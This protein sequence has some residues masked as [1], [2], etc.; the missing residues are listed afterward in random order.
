MYGK[1]FEVNCIENRNDFL[2]LYVTEE[3]LLNI[4]ILGGSKMVLLDVE[5]AK[6]LKKALKQ[7]IKSQELN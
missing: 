5:K 3:D 1:Y 6:K 2:E 4:E 7:Y